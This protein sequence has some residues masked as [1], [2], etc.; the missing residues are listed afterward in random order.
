MW[1]PEHRR[2]ANR[3]GLRYPS[4]LTEDEWVIVAPMIPPARHGVRARQH[5]ATGTLYLFCCAPS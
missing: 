2:S 3:D 4:G 1:T 5:S